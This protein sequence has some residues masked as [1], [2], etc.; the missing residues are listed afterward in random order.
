[1]IPSWPERIRLASGSVRPYWLNFC[2]WLGIRKHIQINC[3]INVLGFFI[4]VSRPTSLHID[5]AALQK[6][7]QLASHYALDSRVICCVKANAY[8]HGMIEVARVLADQSDALAV[9]SLEEARTLRNH[10][11]NIPILLLEGFFDSAELPDLFEQGLW[12]VVHNESQ[13]IALEQFCADSYKDQRLDIWIKIDTGMHRLGFEPTKVAD[14]YRRL[15][16]LSQVGAIRLMTHFACADELENPFTQQQLDCFNESASQYDADCSLANSAGILAWPK[17]HK[18]WIRPGF[19]LYGLSPFG[20]HH[21][22]ASELQPVMSFK[23][24]VIDVKKVSAGEGMGYN[25]YWRAQRTSDIAVL[26]V[27]YGDGYPR[28]SKNGTPVLVNGQ[29]A[30]SVGRVAMDM[31]MADVT[32][33]EGVEVGSEVELWGKQ[34]SVNEVAA[35]SGYSA[36][37]LLT[38]IPPRVQRQYQR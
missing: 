9:A 10:Q 2:L 33:L 24:E 6:N 16:A 14:T 20:Q 25:H 32:D 4:R 27:G 17:S 34:L 22:T 35:H 28:N 21:P 1:M 13:L 29:R 15:K 37:E 38:R 36:Y 26:A 23:T 7:R 11:I 3:H 18:D 19:M 12:S 30:Q 8:G 5:L 31:M